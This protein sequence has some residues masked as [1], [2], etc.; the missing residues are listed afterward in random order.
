MIAGLRE[1]HRALGD[2]ERAS[3]AA[4]EDV[5]HLVRLEGVGDLVEDVH[6]RR[7]TTCFLARLRERAAHADV[8]LDPRQ[9]LAHAGSVGAEVGGAE[10]QGAHRRFFGRHGRHHDHGQV[11]VAL[12]LLESLEQLQPVHLGHHDVEQEDR[13]L[14]LFELGEQPVASGAHRYLVPVFFQDPGQ[15][16]HKRRVVVSDQNSRGGTRHQSVASRSER[17]TLPPLTTSTVVL[18]RGTAPAS[19]AAVVAA[20]DGSTASRQ[21]RH[22]NCTAA[23]MLSSSTSTTPRSRPR[24]RVSSANGMLPTLSVIRPS[25]MLPVRSRRTTFPAASE[26]CSLGAPAASTPQTPALLPA[27]DRPATMPEISPPPPTGT[28]TVST[29]GSCSTISSATVAWPATMSG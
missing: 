3:H 10:A 13:G 14:D 11:A 25:A 27:A 20:P 16:L 28:T 2:V 19:N 1:H 8:R 26:R 29:S 15:R 7:S 4:G 22:R 24:S 17:S 23:R 21:V 12:I 9:Q 18:E 5:V 6:H